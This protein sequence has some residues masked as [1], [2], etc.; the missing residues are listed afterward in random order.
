MSRSGRPKEGDKP[1]LAPLNM[2]TSPDLR[3]KIEAAADE[4]GRS[5]TQEVERRLITS[6]IFDDSRGGPH[7]GAFANMVCSAIQMIE[8]RTGRRWMDD[9]DTFTRV[10]AATEQLLRWNNPEAPA[11]PSVAKAQ[12]HAIEAEA[13][14]AAADEK[15]SEFNA[16]HSLL[17]LGARF[18]GKATGADPREGWSDETHAMEAELQ[19]AALSARAR[20][21]E[22]RRAFDKLFAEAVSSMEEAEAD[23]EAVADALF[24]EIGPKVK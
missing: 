14:A 10:R 24:S 2:R 21:T 8:L 9:F 22:A 7:I 20:A 3:A 23:G 5:L 16:A 1:K 12:R 13:A 11:M 15:L 4:N 6:F 18:L 19:Q 17:T